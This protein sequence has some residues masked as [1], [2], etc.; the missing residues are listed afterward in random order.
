MNQV[1]LEE[2]INRL[3]KELQ[4]SGGD[5]ESRFLDLRAEVDQ[6]RLELRAVRKF[7]AAAHPSFNEQFPRILEQTI[8]EVD[9]EFD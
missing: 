4:L 1:A 5:M 8:E 6:L 9:P 2:A 3:Q 7:L